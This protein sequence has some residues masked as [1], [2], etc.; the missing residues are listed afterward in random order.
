MALP[1]ETTTD[2][3]CG[4]LNIDSEDSKLSDFYENDKNNDQI[5]KIDYILATEHSIYLLRRA[6]NICGSHIDNMAS[7]RRK[8]INE[9]EEKYGKWNDANSKEMW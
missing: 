3:I 8:L 4:F 7:L 2:Y 1:I 9:Y 6:Y 5:Q